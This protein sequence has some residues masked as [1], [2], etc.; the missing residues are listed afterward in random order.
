MTAPSPRP[1][2]IGYRRTSTRKQMGSWHE[3]QRTLEHEC[4]VRGLE[5]VR[6]EGDCGVSGFVGRGGRPGLRRA[7]HALDTEDVVA[8]VVTWYDRLGRGLGYPVMGVDEV[9]GLFETVP[10]PSPVDVLRH[11]A[12]P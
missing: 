5:I 8:V 10:P 12:T 2:V 1:R 3:Q 9:I 11:G 4:A 6:V 7:L